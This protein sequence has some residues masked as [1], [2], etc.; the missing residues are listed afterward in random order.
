MD[1][2]SVLYYYVYSI[3]RKDHEKMSQPKRSYEKFLLNM[4]KTKK[5]QE[6]LNRICDSARKLF[7][8]RGYFKTSINDITSGASVGA[9]TFYIYFAGKLDL[10]KYLLAYY[11][12]FTRHKCR[13]AVEDCTSRVE[14]EREGLRCWFN[15][16]S[17]DKSIYSII[18]ESLHIDK[19]L[20]Y[21]YYSTFAK[22]YI[23]NIN[24]AKLKGEVI[25]INSEVLSY[26][27]IGI[28]NIIGNN[29][30]NF[31]TVHDI[32]TIVDEIMKLLEN[33]M[34]TKK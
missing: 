26:I 15:M 31:E 7:Y 3:F 11:G 33:G 8:E 21:D 27:L 13:I 28:T 22:A 12:S 29:M 25:D 19:T 18:S 6:T 30:E 2:I 32:D 17:K 20:Y 5:G 10:F 16:V 24:S 4:P 14:A 9:G 34:F 1:F 23:R